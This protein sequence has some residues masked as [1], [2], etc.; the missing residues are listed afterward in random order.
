MSR[1]GS[2]IFHYTLVYGHALV[3]NIN[4]CKFDVL[5][6]L[7]DF[8]GRLIKIPGRKFIESLHHEFSWYEL[9]NRHS[10]ALVNFR[11]TYNSVSLNEN[12]H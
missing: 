3:T 1:I 12:I 9:E 8:V 11:C 6:C 2:E 5:D 4:L 10:V 7:I